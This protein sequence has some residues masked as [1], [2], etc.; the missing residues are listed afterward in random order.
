M[1]VKQAF[2]VV[3]IICMVGAIPLIGSLCLGEMLK[4]GMISEEVRFLLI[5]PLS[6]GNVM[7]VKPLIEPIVAWSCR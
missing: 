7:L 5:F 1:S 4:R 3:L 6:V 2:A